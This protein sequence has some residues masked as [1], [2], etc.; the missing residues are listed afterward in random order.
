MGFGVAVRALVRGALIMLAGT[1]AAALLT[2]FVIVG[3]G[4][5]AGS[6]GFV[7][8]S[9]GIAVVLHGLLGHV[10]ARV[11][12]RR[13]RG[14]HGVGAAGG[15]IACAGP[16]LVSLVSQAGAVAATGDA[17]QLAPSCAA[18]LGAALGAVLADRE[19]ERSLPARG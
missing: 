6:A 3:A 1:V 9:V 2:S 19:G 7:W 14:A 4:S 12:A 10:G 17:I 13:L 8:A 5:S 16:V 11:A 15:V 18:L